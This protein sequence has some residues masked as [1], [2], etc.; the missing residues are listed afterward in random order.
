MNNTAEEFLHSLIRFISRRGKPETIISD[1][2]SNFQLVKFLGD[3]AW[4]RTPTDTAITNYCAENGIR[5]KFITENAPWQ[6]GFYERLV[7]LVKSTLKTTIRSKLLSW[8]DFITLL[9]EA[10]AIVNS[11]PI[12]YVHEDVEARFH[13][14]RPVDFLLSQPNAIT[15]SPDGGE[16]S[17][18]DFGDAGKRLVSVWKQRCRT[19]Q[20][21][22]QQWYND[23]L[24][25]LRERP[26]VPHRTGRG[27]I[28]QTPRL[29]Q[30]VLICEPDAPRG[31]WKLGRIT[32]LIQGTDGRV[33]SAELVLWNGIRLRRPL[34][35][36]VPL[37]VENEDTTDDT[38]NDTESNN[39]DTTDDTQND[40]EINNE[41]TTGNAQNDTENNEN[42]ATVPDLL[43][44]VVDQQNENVDNCTTT[45]TDNMP[46]NNLD[47]Q[48]N[49]TPQTVTTP[50]T[51][52]TTQAVNRSNDTTEPPDSQNHGIFFRGIRIDDDDE[53]AFSS[54]DVQRAIDAL[55]RFDP[56][57]YSFSNDEDE[58]SVSH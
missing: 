13:T 6:G 47:Q 55:Q 14:L 26:C 52:N 25:S 43:P 29:D 22:W 42:S 44:D 51:G 50:V 15:E 7:G 30:A 3:R 36:L 31:H 9:A 24:K 28:D 40:T 10:E 8:T 16:V 17:A 20:K 34:N 39:E 18:K 45:P 1:N 27:A 32:Q 11:R 41:D 35:L 33:R 2:A 5:W 21:L 38:Q 49:E 19:L 56:K 23:Y 4:K 58:D 46:S 37:E 53:N 57:E 12:T 54:Q 48:G